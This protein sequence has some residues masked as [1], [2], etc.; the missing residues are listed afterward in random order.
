MDLLEDWWT[1]NSCYEIPRNYAFWTIIG[2]TGAIMHK[3]LLYKHAD[4][5]FTST[6]YIGLIGRQGGSKSTAM[7]FGRGVYEAICPDMEIGPSR[8]SPE[9]IV[10]LMS[11]PACEG[12]YID[13]TG[14][15]ILVR[16]MAF[17]INEFK[18][19]LGRS[20]VDQINF[21]TDIYDSKFYKNAT[22][23]RGQEPVLNPAV[24][25]IMC[26]TPDWMIDN[27]RG[28]LITGGIARRFVLVF[29]DY[30]EQAIPRP[31]VTTDA[32]AAWM[33]VKDRLI[34][35]RS[36]SGLYE[37][38]DAGHLHDIWYRENFERYKKERIPMMQGYLKSK[39]VQLYKLMM[40]L[41][42][43]S[44]KPMR[45]FNKDLFDKSLALLDV[46]EHKMP[47][48]GQAA[49]RNELMA[50]QNRL[51]N[52]VKT[53][54]TSGV[55]GMIQKKKLQALI[56]VDLDPNEQYQIFRYLTDSGQIV[57]G[58]IVFTVQGKPVEKEMVMTPEA[59]ELVKKSQEGK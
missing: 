49:G 37:W 9:Q 8:S 53:T 54:T 10:K 55:L 51:L 2:T 29:E 11:E 1:Y 17:F 6:F 47:E 27:L 16:P 35:V 44:D 25:I 7:S 3:K 46:I 31:V 56:Q 36:T 12:T 24:S 39:H 14:A 40:I 18:N 28:N 26:E 38:G 58:K 15:T 43:T 57:V 50:S 5:H 23:L 34:D 52:I 20:P 4:L 59:N 48:L 30:A 19:F 13:H 41:D 21:L 32:R 33:R 45:L 42:A 22:I